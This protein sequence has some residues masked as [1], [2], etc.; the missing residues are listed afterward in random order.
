[1]RYFHKALFTGVDIKKMIHAASKEQFM[2]KMLWVTL[3]FVFMAFTAFAAD[4]PCPT[5]TINTAEG[6]LTVGFLGHASLLMVYGGKNIYIDPCGQFFDYSKMPKADL[7]LITHEHKDH[8]DLATIEAILTDKTL[9]VLTESCALQYKEGL[10]MRND[11][12]KTI[13]GLK[14]EA[15]P[16]YN[17]VH[18]RP[19]GFP[20]HL[21]GIGNGYIIT[22][23]EKR[24]YVAG[25]TENIPE[26]SEMG[27]IDVAFLPVNLP[28]TM[29]VDMAADAV[30]AIKPRI[31]Y[32]YH[33][34]ETNTAELMNALKPST[35]TEVRLRDMK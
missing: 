25:D 17:I 34:G 32:P 26:M 28:F 4:L 30:K 9:V 18:K 15:V 31:L 7:I 23:A 27:E 6:R 13:M 16:A 33:L 12:V 5:D 35:G 29:T 21:K 3:A 14:V 8:F 10:V 20:F 2:T 1:M 19:S 24:V 22:F 11:E